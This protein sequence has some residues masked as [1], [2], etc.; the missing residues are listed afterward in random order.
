MTKDMNSCEN[1][2]HEYA[3]KV[4]ECGNSFCY[5]CCGSQN[6]DQGGKYEPDFMTCPK[7]GKDYYS[8]RGGDEKS[9]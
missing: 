3:E 9:F 1:G 5:S 4:C 7:C 8:E 2:R 6:V